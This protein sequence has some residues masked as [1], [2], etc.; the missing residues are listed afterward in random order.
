MIKL[1]NFACYVS[2]STKSIDDIYYN[3]RGYFNDTVKY[4]TYIPEIDKFLQKKFDRESCINLLKNSLL[5]DSLLVPQNY[6]PIRRRNKEYYQPEIGFSEV[7]AKWLH[8]KIVDR[9]AFDYFNSPYSLTDP[10]YKAKY[11][12]IYIPLKI[13][14]IKNN[15]TIINK[16]ISN[17]R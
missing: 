13:I 2:D 9:I 16:R 5:I 6:Y 14:Q 15:V 17:S 4:L 3:G 10:F 8:L 11:F 1:K 12:D 7:N